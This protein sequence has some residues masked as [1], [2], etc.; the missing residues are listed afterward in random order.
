M[1]VSYFFL[2]FGVGSKLER[3]R[4][5]DVRWCVSEWGRCVG[6]VL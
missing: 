3:L 1:D 6:D 2:S 4:R 5:Y